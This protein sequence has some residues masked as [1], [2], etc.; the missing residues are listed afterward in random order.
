[1]QEFLKKNDIT[2]N[3]NIYITY[4]YYIYLGKWAYGGNMALVPK[5]IGIRGLSN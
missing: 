4:I 3:I 5:Y 1:M 2:K